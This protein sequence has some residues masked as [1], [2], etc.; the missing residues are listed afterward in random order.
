MR[1]LQSFAAAV[2]VLLLAIS[3][4]LAQEYPQ[5]PIRFVVPFPPGGLVDIL[6]RSIGAKLTEAWGQPV[7]VENRPGSGGIVGADAVAKAP[8]DGYT[9]LLANTNV[10][11]NPSLY[12]SLPYDTAATFVPVV[13]ATSV[14]NILV[15]HTDVAVRS[16]EDLIRLA[17]SSPGKLNYASPSSGTFP[18][19]AFEMFKM[20]AGVNITH[21]PYKGAAPALNAILAKEVEALSSD[22][23]GALP[24]VK[25]GRLRALAI[26]STKRSSAL[27]EVP[28]MAEAGLK[29]Y[30]AIGWQGVMV[31]AGT[32]RAIVERLNRQIV[33]ALKA[34][35]LQSRM[36]AQ[37]VDIVAGTPEEFTSFFRRDMER[38][39]HTVKASGA[40]A[41]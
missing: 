10:A 36:L 21:V 13:H 24:H 3:G 34:P 38:W 20:F 9:L 26:T 30:E 6:A 27:P 15:V 7:V 23:P 29:D 18:H 2:L 40:K 41:E 39:A 19:L 16:L 28:T 8:A 14:P 32:S 25:T 33:A 4:A 1:I 37:G 35:D 22:I 12:K 11:I 5:R 17:K 31:T